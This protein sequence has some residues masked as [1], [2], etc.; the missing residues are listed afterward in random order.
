MGG[1]SAKNKGR[2]GEQQ[3]ARLLNDLFREVLHELGYDPDKV[4]E[5]MPIVQRNQNQTAVGGAD[6]VGI[7]GMSIEVKRQE[8]LNV[9]AWWKQTLTAARADDSLPV[10]IYRQNRK[11]WRVRTYVWSALPEEDGL[12]G[13][14]VVAEMG[15]AQFEYWFKHWIRA[16]YKRVGF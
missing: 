1:R 5:Q 3:V 11:A 4:D 15:Y 12:H 9:S 10:L 8:S 6:L 7:P 16:H 13:P 2:A 14:P